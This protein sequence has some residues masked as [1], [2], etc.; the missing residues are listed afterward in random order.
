MDKYTIEK[1]IGSGSFA[2]VKMGYN[3]QSKEMVAIKLMK[4]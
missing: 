3:N 2:N 1:E 4:R